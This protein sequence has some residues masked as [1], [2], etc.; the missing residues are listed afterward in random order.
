MVAC[1]GTAITATSPRSP[2]ERCTV[3]GSR[4]FGIY[5]ASADSP[6]VACKVNGAG[7]VSENQSATIA[8]RVDGVG[9]HVLRTRVLGST[10]TGILMR[11]SETRIE[12][13]K[14]ENSGNTGIDIAAD[15]VSILRNRVLGSGTTGISVGRD[16]AVV[17]RNQVLR[18]G[19]IGVRVLG[20]RN[21]VARNTIKRTDGDDLI[22][23][24]APGA[25]DLRRN[26]TTR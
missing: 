11:A 17:E 23:E 26:R 2:V 7:T 25:N 1:R 5:T 6:I 20:E 18:S 16:G 15:D 3:E 9:S 12:G 10:G 21:R 14:V 22:D 24:A 8:V 13:C 4:Q 19:G